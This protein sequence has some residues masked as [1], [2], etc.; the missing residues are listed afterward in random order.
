MNS[1]VRRKDAT[2]SCCSVTVLQKTIITDPQPGRVKTLRNRVTHPP[3]RAVAVQNPVFDG[4]NIL[5]GMHPGNMPPN[6]VT[7]VRMHHLDPEERVGCVILGTIA[8]RCQ[9]AGTV[10]CARGAV[11]AERYAVEVRHYCGPWLLAT[12]F[13]CD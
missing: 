6:G 13:P 4:K 5:T 11:A 8:G 9:A 10:F 2:R 12:P 7:I 3:C 1:I